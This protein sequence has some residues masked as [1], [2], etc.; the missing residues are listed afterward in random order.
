M[1]DE[2]RKTVPANSNVCHVCRFSGGFNADFHNL[3]RL[4]VELSLLFMRQL[5]RGYCERNALPISPTQRLQGI[6]YPLK[7]L[8]T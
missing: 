7:N 3:H 1:G 2:E 6:P 4:D 8:F 5:S